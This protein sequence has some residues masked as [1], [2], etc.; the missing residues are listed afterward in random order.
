MGRYA[1]IAIVGALVFAGCGDSTAAAT[2]R[3]EGTL[4]V[5]GG[6]APGVNRGIPGV[7]MVYGTTPSSSKRA[8]LTVRTTRRVSSVRAYRP[9]VRIV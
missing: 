6:P 3:I 1:C 7:V 8:I 4:R 5:V 9:V 2:G